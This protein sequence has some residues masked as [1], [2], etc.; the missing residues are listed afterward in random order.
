M[1]HLLILPILFPAII[2]P[3]LAMAVRHDIVLARVF[4]FAATLGLVLLGCLLMWT[5]SDG[6]IRVYELGAWKAP[7]G[8]VLVLD[9]LSA[10]MVLLTACLATVVQ[11]YAMSG[12]D[13]R[14]HHFYSMFHVLLMGVNGAFLTGDLF[15]LFVFFELLLIASYGL[16]VHGGGPAR[17]KAGLQYISINLIGSV[18]FLMGLGTI[19]G[20]TGT[21]NMAHFAERISQ[22]PESDQAI[23]AVGASLLLV[24]FCMKA[25]LVPLHFW[26]PATYS[27]APPPVAA[28]FSIMSKVG[29]YALIRFSD[30]SLLQQGGP[31]AGL[32]TQW[33]MPCAVLTLVVGA[34]GV[35][36]ARSLSLQAS[37]AGIA[38]IGTMLIAIGLYTPE[39]QAAGLYYMLHST[40]AVAALFLVIDMVIVRRPGAGDGFDPKPF[41]NQGFLAAFFFVAALIVVG[42]PPSSGFL[43]KLQI[44]HH[45][46][47]TDDWPM[48]WAAIL[49][50]SFVTLLGFSQAG[51]FVFWKSSADKKYSPT[52]GEERQATECESQPLALPATAVGMA[53]ALL[54]L[55]TVF[56]SPVMNYL[57][58]TVAQ[59]FDPQQYINAV[60][61]PAKKAGL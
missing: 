14:G 52:V 54:V 44:L 23:M 47:S 15:N 48:L 56:P 13:R 29:V 46:K 58:A 16:M 21:L 36:A 41:P 33:L 24:V 60:L 6:Q 42:L 30:L 35:L 17:F 5:A 4:S 51:S 7:Y 45:L 19:Y 32:G 3:L 2:A 25:A 20:V 8:I 50:A 55:L 27:N 28:L 37:F 31:F 26:L 49:V 61:E 12:W 57:E 59:L 34:V 39:A 9:R 43:G 1:N 11:L 40:L 22:V 10:L 53:W 18:I 38:S